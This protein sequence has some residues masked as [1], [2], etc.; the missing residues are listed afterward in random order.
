MAP[1]I[2]T[3]TDKPVLDN[4][5]IADRLTE[6]AEL[7]SAREANPFRSRAYLQAAA[8]L[9]ELDFPVSKILE[10]GGEAGLVELPGI[11]E[12]IAHSVK[13][14]CES[15]ALPLL[16]QL[17]GKP[18]ESAV[19][20]T[21]AGVGPKTAAL[22]H[23]RLGIDTLEQLEAAAHDGRLDVLPGIGSKRLRSIREALAGRFQRYPKPTKSVAPQNLQVRV[24]ELLS[25]DEEYRRKASQGRLPEVA[26]KRFNPTGQVWLPI[27]RT[28]RNGRGFTAMYSNSALAHQLATTRDWV[29][30]I[31]G[32]LG[33]WTVM[34]G[35][36]ALKGKR[37][38]RGRE[39]EC[40]EYYEAN[41]S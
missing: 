10:S 24:A 6:L 13:T 17:R 21:I 14:L 15:G 40:A 5:V 16:E 20:A 8:T 2:Q 36:G 25:I 12:S 39:Q 22:I 19:L 1:S 34:T 30:I 26:P 23:D 35:V 3:I 18:K 32:K 7:L 41:P 29:I 38:I 37:I 33:Q 28:K 9:R 4:T 11:G 31:A 27:L